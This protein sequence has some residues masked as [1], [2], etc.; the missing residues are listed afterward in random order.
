MK[1]PIDSLMP[2][3]KQL[4]SNKAIAIPYNWQTFRKLERRINNLNENLKIRKY[5]IAS[6]IEFLPFTD[7]PDKR[8]R[9]RIYI[10]RGNI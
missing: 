8:L 9:H 5:H 2:A 3:I 7:S 1:D 10:W 4:T 6:R